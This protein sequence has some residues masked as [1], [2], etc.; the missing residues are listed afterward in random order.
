MAR[1]AYIA[2]VTVFDGL[3]VRRR[4]GV[5]IDGGRIAYSYYLL[6]LQ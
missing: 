5:L 2:G 3:R 4:Q 6:T 1:P